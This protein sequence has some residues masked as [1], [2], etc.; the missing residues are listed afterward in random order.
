MSPLRVSE[1]FDRSERLR[2]R[3]LT[4]DDCHHCER[5]MTRVLTVGGGPHVEGGGTFLFCE[6]CRELWLRAERERRRPARRATAGRP[7]SRGRGTL[8]PWT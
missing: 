5:P 8:P 4:V 3:R 6:R 7:D 2:E 1:K